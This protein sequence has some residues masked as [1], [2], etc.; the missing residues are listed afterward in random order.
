M[1]EEKKEMG[2]SPVNPVPS[3]CMTKHSPVKSY[4]RVAV[5]LHTSLTS[6]LHG[7]SVN[8]TPWQLCP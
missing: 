4:E 3:S 7:G 2:S 5:S 8:F 6:I 1:E